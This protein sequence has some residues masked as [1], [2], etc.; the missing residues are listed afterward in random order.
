MSTPRA[1]TTAGPRAPASIAPLARALA[2]AVGPRVLVRTTPDGVRIGMPAKRSPFRTPKRKPFALPTKHNPLSSAAGRAQPVRRGARVPLRPRLV[3]ALAPG[4]R[5]DR[6]GRARPPGA[7][8]LLPRHARPGRVLH[9][10]RAR[11]R[12]HDHAPRT[13]A[14]AASS[15]ARSILKRCSLVAWISPDRSTRARARWM[16]STPASTRQRR[17][18]GYAHPDAWSPGWIW[19][20]QSPAA[21]CRIGLSA[22][23]CVA[24]VV[25]GFAV[26]PGVR[27]R[28]W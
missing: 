22:G 26:G 21:E 16:R 20:T 17:D 12:P 24:H 19:K 15:Q 10:H 14:V 23:S 4:G 13:K 1:I 28:Y 7:R 8:P 25:G 5:G 2:L 3:R 9:P 11:Q 6:R 18:R 27:T